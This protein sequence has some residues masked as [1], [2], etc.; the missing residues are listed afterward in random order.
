[1]ADDARERHE[2]HGEPAGKLSPRTAAFVMQRFPPTNWDELVTKD[3][4]RDQMQQLEVRLE[5]CI[6]AKFELRLND[7]MTSQTR[8]ISAGQVGA[9]VAT[10]IA[11]IAAAQLA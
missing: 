2:V 7:A 8:T 1:M 4:L 6:D 11:I 5:H 3:H 10:A 9:A